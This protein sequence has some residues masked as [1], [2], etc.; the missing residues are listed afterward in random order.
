MTRRA[1]SRAASPASDRRRLAAA[2]K[3]QERKIRPIR[4]TLMMRKTMHDAA[5]YIRSLA[6]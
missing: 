1:Q 3:R 5:A 6:H 4:A 2:K